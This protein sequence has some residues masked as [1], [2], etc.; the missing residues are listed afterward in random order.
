M[1]GKLSG[2]LVKVMDYILQY[3]YNSLLPIVT[4]IFLSVGGVAELGSC[5]IH[6]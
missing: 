4:V 6:L 3:I 2:L 1:N 5:T